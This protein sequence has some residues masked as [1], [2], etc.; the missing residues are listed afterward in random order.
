MGKKTNKKLKKK[1]KKLAKKAVKIASSASS[2]PAHI[3]GKGDFLVPTKSLK[4]IAGVPIG[5]AAG[6]AIGSLF[7]GVGGKVG[8][9]IG[10]KLHRGI[11]WLTGWGDYRVHNAKF[12]DHMSGAEN[13]SVLMSGR[14]PEFASG[15]GTHKNVICFEERVASIYSSVDFNSTN[16]AI[17]PGVSQTFP[18]L[19][20][21]ACCYQQYQMLGCLFHFRSLLA[22]S[23]STFQSLGEVAMATQYDPARTVGFRSMNE[24]LNSDFAS[25]SKGSRSFFHMIEC[26]PKETGIMTKYLRNQGVSAD[27]E[28]WDDIGDLQVVTQGFPSAGVLVGELWVTYK[29][30]LLKPSMNAMVSAK[31]WHGK[32][33]SGTV[34]NGGNET[35]SSIFSRVSTVTG[36]SLPAMSSSLS[37]GVQGISMP[38]IPGNYTVTVVCYLSG[39]TLTGGWTFSTSSSDVSLVYGFA[40]GQAIVSALTSSYAM[41]SIMFDY[42]AKTTAGA[43]DLVFGARPNWTGNATPYYDFF[44]TT[45]ETGLSQTYNML[46]AKDSLEDRIERSLMAKL[47]ITVPVVA[48]TTADFV[49]RVVIGDNGQIDSIQQWPYDGPVPPSGDANADVA[50]AERAISQAAALS[51]AA[52]A[53][54]PTGAQTPMSAA[55]I[56]VPPSGVSTPS[57]SRTAVQLATAAASS[58]RYF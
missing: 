39:G 31:T 1:A 20:S 23:V 30:A 55:L 26:A 6:T 54:S 52:S 14:I 11:K 33:T 40:N 57:G 18:Y 24:V 10:D 4:T 41:M 53:S 7:G 13:G 25:S 58:R 50:E 38:K 12:H 46:S 42:S 21:L 17:N 15:G 56:S 51:A 28:R 27:A 29:V 9:F 36:S 48:D 43:A 5:E 44:L 32:N 3:R 19:S 8:G 16:F 34:I 37:D 45:R 2:G 35:T 49:Q 22:D 47:N